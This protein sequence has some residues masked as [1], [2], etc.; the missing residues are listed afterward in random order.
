M[1]LGSLSDI[2][3]LLSLLVCYSLSW[4]SP[5]ILSATPSPGL[6]PSVCLQLPLPV[7]LVVHSV[8]SCSFTIADPTDTASIC[9]HTPG[10]CPH[11]LPVP[12]ALLNA[13]RCPCVSELVLL[14]H[15]LRLLLL[16]LS[17]GLGE[18]GSGCCGCGTSKSPLPSSVLFLDRRR[19][20]M[21]RRL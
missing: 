16:P 20:A 18:L 13:E 8:H 9:S 14:L 10:D 5:A 2:S 19:P 12:A 3:L 11:E 7:P 15:L 21:L 4:S 17:G 1:D 6:P